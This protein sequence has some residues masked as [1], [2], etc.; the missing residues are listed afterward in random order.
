MFI[1]G[2]KTLWSFLLRLVYTSVVTGI[3]ETEICLNVHIGTGT[4]Q[5]CNLCCAPNKTKEREYMQG[6]NATILKCR[7]GDITLQKLISG[8]AV[9]TKPEP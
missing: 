8:E 3:V 7:V 5:I 1:V 6:E 4:S 9:F 2:Q